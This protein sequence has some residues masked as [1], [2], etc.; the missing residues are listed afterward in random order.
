[1]SPLV[2]GY[3][4]EKNASS[5][6][7]STEAVDNTEE[8][9]YIWVHLNSGH[10]KA[11]D[12]LLEKSHL[13]DLVV[14]S[15]LHSEN[16]PNVFKFSE[17]T[18]I[19]LRGVNTLPDQLVEDFNAINIL[20][21]SKRIITIRQHRILAIEDIVNQIENG[22]PPQNVG[23]FLSMLVKKINFRI[24]EV[25]VAIEEATDDLEEKIIA[26]DFDNVRSELSNLRRRIIQ[27]RKYLIPQRD[28][29]NRLIV[30]DY[31]WLDDISKLYLR[32]AAEKM[33]RYIEDIDNIK[34]HILLHQEEIGNKLN[35]EMNNT[36]YRLSIIS[37][38]FLPLG[39]ITGL[40]GVNIAGL[41][42]MENEN[43]FI[44]LTILS[45]LFLILGFAY[46]KVRKQI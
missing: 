13:S 18:M 3:V 6:K 38:L 25:I 43:A 2:H 7:I 24:G 14:E 28:V 15:M 23:A 36:M 26:K 46:F 20:I 29:L 45:G 30:D 37:A 19:T 10:K 35:E 9:E 40:L 16:R 5:K 31:E 22:K 33:N 1:M 41:P 21:D 17:G 12:W 11:K 39:F 32:N 8:I 42:G 27:I 34:E 4:I 44:L